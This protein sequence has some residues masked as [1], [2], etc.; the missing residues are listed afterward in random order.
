MIA[1]PLLTPPPTDAFLPRNDTAPTAE[2]VAQDF[3]AL[4]I[5]QLLTAMRAT[6]DH[7]ADPLHGGFAREVFDDMLY[8]EY[9]TILAER[10]A[11]A[12]NHLIADSIE[13]TG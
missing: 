5:D 1:N 11:F 12:I 9:A 13:R 2:S 8:K 7:S 3:S 6:I 10:D 4:L